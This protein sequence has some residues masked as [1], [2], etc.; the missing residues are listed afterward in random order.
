MNVNT[1]RNYNEDSTNENEAAN[2]YAADMAE[3][4]DR[5][6]QNTFDEGVEHELL[7][8]YVDE[9]GVTHK[10]YTLREM[11]GEDEEYINRSDIK[12][13]GAKVSTAL[14]SRCVT[15]I[16]TLT[17]KAV[18]PKKWDE[19]FK[20]ILVGDRDIMLLELRKQ[21]IGS[22][23]EVVHTC[24]NKECRAKLKTI[25][26]VDELE[27]TPYDGLREIPFEL[28]KGYVDGKGVLHRNGKM[29][30]PNGL[31]GEILTPV[32]K[33]NMAKAES[34]LLSRICQFD[35]GAYIDQSVMAKLSM[36][37]RNYL[38]ELLNEHSFGVNMTVP[39]MCDRCGEEFTGNLN[40]SNF[41]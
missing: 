40:Q 37:D 1:K 22:S 34:L 25:I 35:D 11:T 7:A 12:S 8:G 10:T 38:Q 32:A 5:E 30:R 31:D 20:S 13:N 3:I 19:I 33:N 36:K 18:G 15:S 29:R 41:I 14:L 28:P 6:A 2:E 39:V 16:G 27:I 9:N 4:A 21:S 24:P 23:I 17:K 26:D